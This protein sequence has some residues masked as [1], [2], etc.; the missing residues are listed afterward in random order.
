[1]KNIKLILSILTITLVLGCSNDNNDV[2]LEGV[3]APANISALTTITQDN[4]GNVTFLPRGEGVTGYEIYFGDGTVEP[5]YVNVG[6]I[7]T[8]KYKEGKFSAKIVGTT[9]NGKKTEVI[10]DVTVSF[11]APKNFEPTITIGTNLS[12]N[13]TAKAELETFFQVYFGDKA[14]EV[15]T[16]FMEGEVIKHTYAAAGTYQ[17]KVVALSGGAATTQKIQSVTVTNLLAA[18]IPTIPAANVISLFSDSYTN[19]AVDTWRTSW[20]QAN[21]EDIDISGNKAKKYSSLNFVGVEATT[22]PI[23][24]TAMTFF[25]IDIWSSTFTEFKIKLVDFGA[26]GVFG[27]GDDKE[28]EIKISNPEKEKWVSLD[29]PLSDF[30]GLTTRSHIAQ[31]IFVGAPSGSTTVYVDNVFFYNKVGSV[32]A[33]PAPSLPASKVISMFS[34]SYTNVSVDTW[35]TSWSSATLTD[36]AISGNATKKY[37]ELDFVGIETT[38]TPIDATAMTHFHTDVWSSDFTTFKIKLVDFGLNGVFGG[39][40]DKEHEITITAPAKGEWISLDIP[41]SS[42]SGL[43]T[44]AHIAQLIYVGAPAGNNTVYIDNVYFHD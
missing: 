12:I 19:V 23:N 38:T 5:A 32:T 21:L 9:I 34:D 27:G 1:M 44:R 37:S 3:N 20:S 26:N 24:A 6:A 25:H 10:Q 35:R 8:H 41:L 29:M 28:H 31:I 22:T 30:T 4:S 39:G 14:S 15:P 36:L 18:P 43:T 33:A 11:L 40:D 13:V 17:V 7:T 2:D 42:F 16:N